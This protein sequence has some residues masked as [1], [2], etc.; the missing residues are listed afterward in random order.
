MTFLQKVKKVFRRKSQNDNLPKTY[1]IESGDTLWCLS[2]KFNVPYEE[3]LNVNPQITNPNFVYI[4]QIINIPSIDQ[5]HT[6]TINT[7][8]ELNT[9]NPIQDNNTYTV[10]SGDTLWCLSSKFNVPYEELLKANPQITN[11]NFIYIGQIINIPIGEAC[12]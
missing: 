3:L 9:S 1:T 11:P 6:N 5:N 2:C 8:D 10:K 7:T 4:G 12:T